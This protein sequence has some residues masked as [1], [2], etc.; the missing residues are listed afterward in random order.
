VNAIAATDLA[1]PPFRGLDVLLA[2]LSRTPGASVGVTP[3]SVARADDGSL[4]VIDC[5][6]P[7]GESDFRRHRAA[8]TALVDPVAMGCRPDAR[9]QLN[10]LADE[11]L[12]NSPIDCSANRQGT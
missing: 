2:R 6:V 12:G 4:L 11:R 3:L 5:A 7:A 1:R 8:L 9:V 10:L